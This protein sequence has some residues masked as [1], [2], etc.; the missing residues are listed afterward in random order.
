MKTRNAVRVLCCA[1]VIV[2]ISCIGASLLQTSGETVTVTELKIPTNDGQYVS[3]ELF[4]PKT[5]SAKNKVPLV[6]TTHGYL[7]SKEMQ[8]MASIEL[9]RRGIA[10]MAFDMYD[11]GESSPYN[12][13]FFQGIF[14]D[15]GGM[16]PLVEYAYSNLNYVDKTKIGVMGHSLG[17]IATW[18]TLSYYSA[19]YD[20]KI[21]AAKDPSSD[22]G[23]QITPAEQ[24][25][26]NAAMKV[27]AG[28]PTSMPQIPAIPGGPKVGDLHANVGINA[29]YYDEA[30]AAWPGGNGDLSGH[31]KISLDF[32]NSVL[33][34]DQHITSAELGKVYGNVADK[35]MR[36]VYNPKDTHPLQTISPAS[37]AV[38][39]DFFTQAFQ[40]N[41]PIPSGNSTAFPK[42]LFN[43][44]GVIGIL[45]TI[46]PFGA[47]LLKVPAFASLQ[48]SEVPPELP[49]LTNGRRKWSFWGCWAL[50][51]IVSGVTFLPLAQL[52][53]VI[54]P[55]AASYTGTS[56]FPQPQS[57][58]LIIWGVF[59]AVIGLVL[60]FV[61]YKIGKKDG[62][63][64]EMLGIKISAK[65]FLKTLALA[66]CVFVGFYGIVMFASYFF[67]TDFRFWLLA[68][69]G[70]TPDKIFVML[71]YLPFFFIFF[72]ANSIMVN[73]SSRVSGQKQWFN[74]L[75]CGLA[76][77]L[78]LVIVIVMQYGTL[79]ATGVCLWTGPWVWPTCAFALVPLMFVVPY[80]SRY[81]FKATGKVWLGALTN[82][83]IFT[84]ILVANT[85]T[86]LPLK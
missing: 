43:F 29:G 5:A 55:T 41:N 25:A 40:M 19:Q 50:S 22:G 71:Q 49:G 36:V 33:P 7:N 9:S 48:T 51:W 81:L 10:V 83:L 4:L 62:V 34:A 76:N 28:L 86:F 12:G 74:L 1:L 56:W 73:S 26:A 13:T 77:V 67:N 3:T 30:S 35:T 69:K 85:S 80:I 57:N 24:A 84:M 82:S 27:S 47:L 14:Q 23:T 32:I 6:I 61:N 15:G 45:M 53:S 59:N 44:L 60:F 52:Q 75:L 54:F 66:V 70:F 38:T 65:E 63:A 11:N 64:P 21:K 8:D 68:I 58:A 31:S 78:G 16:I 37:A 20:A 79:F 2:L 46:V 18:T 42:E 17:G 39:V 72:A